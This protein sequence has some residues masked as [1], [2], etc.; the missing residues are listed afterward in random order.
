[1]FEQILGRLIGGGLGEAATDAM[2]SAAIDVLVEQ[3]TP[4][5]TATILGVRA[6]LLEQLTPAPP[7]TLRAELAAVGLNLTDAQVVTIWGATF[8]A[9]A[10]ERAASKPQLQLVE[11]GGAAAS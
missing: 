11:A 3:L 1:M 4:F 9:I 6:K 8:R 10:S 5:L 2:S 7:A